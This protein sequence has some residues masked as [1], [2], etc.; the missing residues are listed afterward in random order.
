MSAASKVG[1]T[2]AQLRAEKAANAAAAAAA[3]APVAVT[4]PQ[5]RPPA[6]PSGA[7]PVTGRGTLRGR[8]AAAAARPAAP[9]SQTAPFEAVRRDRDP[10]IL[11]FRLAPTHVAYA[12]TLR[13]A[14][15]TEVETV[16]IRADIKADGSTSDVKITKNSTPM[17]N[18][19][20]AHRIG[21]IP[22]YIR[23]PLRWNPDTITFKLDITNE[24][25]EARDIVASDIEVYEDKGSEEPPTRL[26]NKN[27]F[28]AN[29]LTRSTQNPEGDTC[30]L[31]VL[32]GKVSGQ[33]PESLSFTAKAT[34]GTG[35][36]N[37]RFMPVTSRCAYG[38]TL[39]EDPDRRREFFTR[40]LDISKKVK[41]ADLESDATKKAQFQREFDTMEVQRCYKI[42]EKGEPYSFDFTVESIGVLDPTYIVGRALAILEAKVLRL[43]SI[44]TGDLPEGLRI[45]PADARMKGFDFFFTGEDHTLGNLLQTWMEQN[46]MDS[47]DI[48]FVGYKVPHP[49]RD[50]MVLRVGVED[51]KDV[52]ARVAVARAARSLAQMFRDWSA[53]WAGASNGI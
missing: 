1:K 47:G 29:P 37:A 42:N 49:L 41:I 7:P 10:D 19:M 11:Q 27:F 15:L 4:K 39:D 33:E 13:R 40:W 9:A 31:T 16:A 52:S 45:L 23:D 6:P 21:L 24:S 32:K 48:T 50:E 44:D 30:L 34:L 2:L 18:E 14:M 35:R 25:S 36:E 12:N 22:L 43:A 38:Y 28:R 3:P 53:A 20:L 51:G 26:A 8:R 17:S 5:Q 46:L